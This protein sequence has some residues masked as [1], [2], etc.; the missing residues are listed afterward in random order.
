MKSEVPARV[1]GLLG[2]G[3]VAIGFSPILVRFAS[4]APGIVVALWR[5]GFAAL[6]LIPVVLARRKDVLQRLSLRDNVLIVVSG[7]LLGAHFV[8]W[9]ES[10]Y[11]TSVASASVLVTT[12]PIFI[13]LLGFLFLR[14][15][16]SFR[17]ILAIA[18]AVGGALLI[19]YSDGS[20]QTYPT[21]RLGNLLALTAALCFSIYLLIGRAVRRRLSLLTYLFPL[22]VVTALTTLAVALAQGVDL[23]PSASVLMLCL[24][25]AVGPQL[26]G[27][28]SFNYA[29]K[30]VPAA[31]IGLLSLLEPVIASGLAYVFFDE[32]P[33]TVALLGMML[34]LLAVASVFWK[35]RA[36]PSDPSEG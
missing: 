32:Q 17:T 36:K 6:L 9:I 33:S 24:M 18:V 22:Y 11:H 26:L 1:V 31:I 21:A 30:Y 8:T 23:I 13:A 25:M 35:R 7:I 10:L 19:S 16:L 20:N 12:S 15:R 29:V 28:G 34:V 3:L 4:E 27:H 2:A 14:E 5:T